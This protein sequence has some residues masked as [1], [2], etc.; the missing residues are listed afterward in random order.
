MYYLQYSYV[1]YVV[2]FLKITGLLATKFNLPFLFAKIG[3]YESE[4]SLN[5]FRSYNK[6]CLIIIIIKL[7]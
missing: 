1:F 5:H 7:L 2:S 3:K 6:R 4:L